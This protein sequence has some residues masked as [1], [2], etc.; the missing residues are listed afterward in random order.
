MPA[1]SKAQQRLM[2][3]AAN[4][5]TFPMAKQVQQSMS[6]AQMGDFARGPM[7]GKP[8]HVPRPARAAVAVARPSM[9]E[10]RAPTYPHSN[11]GRYLHPP[12]GRGK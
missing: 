8:A 3:A 12:K 1:K 7:A 4:G 11:L 9:P 6:L 5:A 10:G 2:A